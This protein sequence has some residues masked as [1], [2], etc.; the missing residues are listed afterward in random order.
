[1]PKQDHLVCFLGGSLL[2]GA[3]SAPA[4]DVEV[5]SI[6]PRVDELTEAGKRDWRNGVGL[7]R[8]CV[9]THETRTWVFALLL[10]VLTAILTMRMDCTEGYR[11]KLLTSGSRVTPCR[12][13]GACP[14]IGISRVVQWASLLHLMPGIS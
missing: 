12:M 11:L 10:R 3:V 6:P 14:Q 4:P 2:L 1:M 9:K 7:I 5:V 13:T 8:T